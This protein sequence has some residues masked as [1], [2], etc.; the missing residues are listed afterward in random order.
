MTKFKTIENNTTFI[1]DQFYS[2]PTTGRITLF[3]I[4]FNLSNLLLDEISILA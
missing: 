4:G 3:H 2:D 1:N